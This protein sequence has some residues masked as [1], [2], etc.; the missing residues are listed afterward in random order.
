MGLGIYSIMKQS[1]SVVNFNVNIDLLKSLSIQ[2]IIVTFVITGI[3]NKDILLPYLLL[4]GASLYFKT[5][6]SKI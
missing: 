1:F 3:F 6:E 5:Y 4:L 2:L